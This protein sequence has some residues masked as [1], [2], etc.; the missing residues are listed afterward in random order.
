MGYAGYTRRPV[1]PNLD[2]L[3]AKSLRL[4]RAWSTSTH[5]N[6]AQMAILSSLFPRRGATLDT[7]EVIDYPR[8][9]PQ[10][11]LRPLGYDTATFSSQNEDWQGM[12]RFQTT[13]T[14]HLF[15]DSRSYS[16]PKMGRT[17]DSKV[18]DDATTSAAIEWLERPRTGPFYLYLNLQQTHWGYRLPPGARG[19][20]GG[21]SIQ[22]LRARGLEVSFMRVSPEAR[23]GVRVAFDNA[24]HFVD[25]QVGRLLRALDTM[26][27]LDDT[28][29]I[30]TADHGESFGERGI[31]AHGKT[32]REP[33]ARP[34][35]LVHYPRRI[36]AGDVDAPVSH[37]DVIPTVLELLGL[38]PYPGHQGESFLDLAA[39]E[40]E[41]RAVFLTMQGLRQ[42]DAVVCYPWKLVRDHTARR[43][44]LYDLAR[45]P[46]E[47]RDLADV[48]ASVMR[49]LEATLSTQITAQ[50][51]YHARS[52]RGEEHRFAPRVAR[53]PELPAR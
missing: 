8:A 12:R 39:F 23:E 16:G 4:R 26:G 7:Y 41:K 47:R 46:G 25:S 2:R 24:L 30:V 6:Y 35:L 11:L 44:E 5:S 14:P 45:D 22:E 50:L 32:L 3:A 36:A 27:K 53:C 19:P 17:A 1:T 29:V 48:R 38:P 37:L 9:L 33:E 28:L 18:P 43:V 40:R 10:D 49:R 42:A 15:F 52:R 31:D 21:P 20:F 51:G 34:P 13:S